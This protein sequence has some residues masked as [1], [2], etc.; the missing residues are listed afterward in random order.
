MARGENDPALDNFIDSISKRLA[1]AGG[2]GS[3]L[4]YA[5]V[6]GLFDQV[7]PLQKAIGKNERLDIPEIVRT[8]GLDAT[9]GARLTPQQAQTSST[10]GKYDT[11]REQLKRNFGQTGSGKD[12]VALNK[13]I[14]DTL[15]EMR[16]KQ[17]EE[18]AP[19]AT[20]SAGD[21]P[22]AKEFSLFPEK[23]SMVDAPATAPSKAPTAE[24]APAEVPAKPAANTPAA[25]SAGRD[26][27]ALFMKATGTEFD[28]KSRLDIA[29]KSE[30]EALLKNKPELAGKS[31]TQVALQYYRQMENAKRK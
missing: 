19:A 10:Y 12:K 31:D 20:G 4:K 13:A 14:D 17:Y 22:L 30:L 8:Q 15:I 3:Y 6:K 11:L 29:R 5:D 7:A 28:P 25:P 9:R 23:G 21:S 16:N 24:M 27:N 1:E 26:L 18:P 2:D